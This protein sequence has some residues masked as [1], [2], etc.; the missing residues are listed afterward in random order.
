MSY[1]ARQGSY[2]SGWRDPFT[3]IE[4]MRRRLEELFPQGSAQVEAAGWTGGLDLEETGDGWVLEAPLPGVPPEAVDVELTDRE[5]AIRGEATSH[6][7]E[8]SGRPHRFSY[9]FPLPGEVMADRVEAR[10]EHGVLTVRLPRS[11]ARSRKIPIGGST[12]IRTSA[13]EQ[14]TEPLPRARSSSHTPSSG[15]ASPPGTAPTTAPPYHDQATTQPGA[16]YQEPDY[17]DYPD[18]SATGRSPVP[19]QDPLPPGYPALSQEPV[20]PED[21]YPGQPPFFPW[22]NHSRSD[23]DHPT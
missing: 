17:S 5:L 10:L 15:E 13:D 14:P 8:P 2:H 12:G 22:P 4:A 21:D 3:E 6:Q 19:G 20:T 7:R 1:P 16:G 18:T 9:R 11:S 23:Q